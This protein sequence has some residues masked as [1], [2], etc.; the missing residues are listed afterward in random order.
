MLIFGKCLEPETGA[1]YQKQHQTAMHHGE[2]GVPFQILQPVFLKQDV[3]SPWGAVWVLSG[4]C[5][6]WTLFALD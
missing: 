3:L 2:G 1:H 6:Y 5:K 4:Y